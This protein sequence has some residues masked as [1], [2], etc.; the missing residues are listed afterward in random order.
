MKD[1]KKFFPLV[2][3]EEQSDGSLKVY[4]LVTA[5][6]PDRDGEVCHYASTAPYY[7]AMAEE[8]K[9]ATSIPGVDPS[10]APLRYMHG[11]DAVGKGTRMDFDDKSK[12][13]MMGFDVVDPAAVAKV[14]KGV[15]TGFSHGGQYV[16]T[17]IQRNPDGKEYTYY[18]AK[19]GEVS[20]VDSPCL[21][22]AR[23]EYVKADGS[24]EQRKFTP[25]AGSDLEVNGQGKLQLSTGDV[26]RIA[27][28]T[29]ALVKAQ[30][31]QDEDDDEDGEGKDGKDGKDKAATPAGEGSGAA[32]HESGKA[33][34]TPDLGV[35]E[36]KLDPPSPIAFENK[37]DNGG[38]PQG[39]KADGAD[40]LDKKDKKT[41]RVAGK[42]LTADNFAYVGDPDRTETWKF[43]IHDAAHTRN[44]LARWS[45]AKG[46]PASE[47]GKVR[48]KI[49]AAAK[50]FGIE[51]S[52]E[53]DK[54]KAAY[55]FMASGAV[56]ENIRDA[57]F[58]A[59]TLKDDGSPVFNTKAETYA[60]DVARA[61]NGAA[62]DAMLKSLWDVK[63]FVEVIN[64]LFF[65]QR[66][67]YDEAVFEGDNSVIPGD[68][69]G[70]LERLCEIFVALV[71]EET[72]ELIA[73]ISGQK[74]AKAMNTT[75][76]EK[77]RKSVA[78]HLKA[79]HS[80]V[81]DHHEKTVGMH[82]THHD[83]VHAHVEKI[84]KALKAAGIDMAK[85]KDA[86]ESLDA[87]K[88]M[89]TAH[90][91]KA[92]G[93][94]GKFHDAMRGHLNK[95]AKAIGAEEEEVEGA[96]PDD[97]QLEEGGSQGP[98]P[99]KPH[100]HKSFTLEDVAA[101][102]KAA[103]DERD[104][105]D[106][107]NITK[108]VAQI[109]GG[110]NGNGAAPA[111]G[112]GDRNQVIKTDKQPHQTNIAGKDQDTAGTGAA[113]ANKTDTADALKEVDVRKAVAGDTTEVLKMAR[114]I[115]AAPG[116]L[117]SHLSGVIAKMDRG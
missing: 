93:H 97:I 75:D 83:K 72:A 9:K 78:D 86:H 5:E 91:D 52:G 28:A 41:K 84:K 35:G 42:D 80:M 104:K 33:K 18:T 29:A 46:I 66:C 114:T 116:G 15:L 70:L 12:T 2:K 50:K 37:T 17:W 16:K 55:F 87:L 31:E 23:F 113:L 59:T 8:F 110:G 74:G 102:V 48:A 109:N 67:L 60:V 49:E 39:A 65:V 14:K 73:A 62:P 107:E 82:K 1:F 90:H 32:S 19:V 108:I 89:A 99:G 21:E 106:E 88:T 44:A 7:R 6:Q 117:P 25:D 105:Q 63:S 11:L 92:V 56:P 61:V 36:A 98:Y 95:M 76:L 101:V 85:A 111:A 71:G 57:V 27:D 54:I 30:D 115:K 51:V 58:K 112:V 64:T 94:S 3:A 100:E 53:A 24:K 34:E 47:K 45:Q 103:L 77:A 43:P 10:I 40:D 13:I 81:S 96:G 4:G 22:S 26:L 38:Q 69:A 68:L 20:L 79:G